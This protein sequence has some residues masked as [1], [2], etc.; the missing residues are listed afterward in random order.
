MSSERLREPT[1]KARKTVL[2]VGA[3]GQACEQLRAL[4][5][6]QTDLDLRIRVVGNTRIDGA[7]LPHADL[8]LLDVGE[9]GSDMLHEWTTRQN[10]QP[11][12]LIVLGPASDAPLMRRAMQAGA[13]DFLTQPV[14]LEQLVES[15][16][17]IL[18]ESA[19]G[20]GGGQPGGRLTAVI[21]AKGGSGSSFVACNL[22][23]MLI[24][25]LNRPTALIDMD[26]QF[27]A[28]PLALD[29][30][31]RDTLFEAIGAAEHLDPVALKGHMTKHKSGLHVLGAMSEQL[32]MPSEV[33]VDAVQKLLGVALQSYA[34][35]V[36][37]LPR[38]IDALTSLVLANADHVL[39]VTQ[40][41]FA[42]LRDTKR[43]FG[44]LQSY[45]GVP[46]E[47][48]SLLINR[49]QDK[50]SISAEDFGEAIH[51]Q[52]ILLVPNDFAHVTESLNLGVPVYEGA[53][54]AA[55]TR[56]LCNITEQLD[57]GAPVAPAPP[58]AR[59]ARQVLRR[60]LRLGT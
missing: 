9:R 17:A 57:E 35:V 34:H 2:L 28:L 8:A 48:I 49:N 21:N 7:A 24:A 18:S 53:R 16:R 13:R 6:P 58:A 19:S 45:V 30:N 54:N 29:L 14:A 15:V 42:H 27:G 38:Q 43:M 41:S 26:L 59:P 23:H 46:N 1:L 25:H 51:P 40:Q 33:S 55:V 39:V 36:I 20:G 4:L 31:T 22:A 5:E 52:Q 60:V 10:A 11:V 56:A 50:H 32:V 44:L 37:D 47:R 12:P 3:T